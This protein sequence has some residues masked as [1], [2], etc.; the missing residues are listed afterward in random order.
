MRNRV[1]WEIDPIQKAREVIRRTAPYFA[2]GIYRFRPV[3]VESLGSL[4]VDSSARL[5]Y[6]PTALE[7][8]ALIDVAGAIV[9]ELL[10]LLDR[11]A[12]R[13]VSAGVHS[14]E[15]AAI[16]NVAA[17]VALF[18]L[19]KTGQ[20]SLKGHLRPSHF[21][22]K[23]NKPVEYYYKELQQ[24]DE[25]PQP[26]TG[27]PA[28]GKPAPGKGRSGSCA[29]GRQEPWE[30]PPDGDADEQQMQRELLRRMVAQAVRAHSK[31]AGTVP[32]CLQTLVDDLLEPP[33]IPWRR[34]LAGMVRGGLIAAGK[35]D[36]SRQRPSRRQQ[37]TPAVLRPALVRPTPRVAIVLDTSGSMGMPELTDALVE[38]KGVI[39]SLTHQEAL[40]VLSCDAAVHAVQSVWSVSQIEPTGGGGT[41]MTPGLKAAARLRPAPTVVIVITDG[42]VFDWPARR[43]MAC[44]VIVLLVGGHDRN[45]TNTPTW[46]RVLEVFP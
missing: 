42:Y 29:S 17:D 1:D 6:D 21:G 8:W 38:I 37:S 27:K 26:D 40:T 13:A 39:G 12:E 24:R 23:P 31:I 30:Q 46:A 19:M 28:P 4:A 33:K 22:L 3:K 7:D 36:F 45:S 16:W 35:S 43:P 9:H 18:R 44:P 11:H 5:Y 20:W 15:D 14:K 10:H 34:V 25:P 2:T 32:E 41:A